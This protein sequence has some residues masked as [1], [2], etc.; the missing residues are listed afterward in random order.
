VYSQKN[1]TAAKRLKKNKNQISGL[2]NSMGYN[3][4]NRISDFLRNRQKINPVDLIIRDISW[5]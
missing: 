2:I 5:I 4:K 3:E 1:D